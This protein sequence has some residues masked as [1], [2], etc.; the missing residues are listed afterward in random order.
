MLNSR[1]DGTVFLRLTSADG[2][3]RAYLGVEPDGT[4]NLRLFGPDG[5]TRA[6]LEVVGNRPRLTLRDSTQRV[7]WS[8]P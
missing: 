1:G 2:V 3:N 6:A 8:A 5:R 4:P 7:V